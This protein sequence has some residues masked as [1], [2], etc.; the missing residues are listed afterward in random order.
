MSGRS[1]DSVKLPN[2]TVLYGIILT[3]LGIFVLVGSATRLYELREFFPLRLPEQ[4]NEFILN[5]VPFIL[6]T[7]ITTVA[8]LAGFIVGVNWILNGFRQMSRLR[9][10]LRWAGDYYQPESVSLGLKEGKLRSYDK[11]PSI[12]FSLLARLWGNARFISE[13]P[14]EIV[15]WN[16]RFLWKA[17]FIGIA[18]H[19]LFRLL[20]LAPPYLCGLGLG[21]GYVVPSPYPLYNLL[22]A[23]CV[24]RILIALSLTPLRKPVVGREMDSMIVE[25]RGHPSVFFSILEE[26][27]R[28]FAHRGFP[29][30]IYRSRPVVCNDGETL[31]GT[32]IESFPEHV[33]TSCRFAALFS[34]TVGAMM[35]LVGFLQIIFM[36]YPTFSVSYED[37]FRLYLLSL[38]V[39][40]IMNVAII[41]FGKSF[42]EQARSLMSIYRFKSNLVYVE[43]KGDFDKKLPDLGKIVSKDRLF[44]PLCQCAFNVRYFSAEAI[45]E[46]VNPEGVRELVGLETSGR[47]AKDI[48]RLKFLPFQVKFVDRYPSSWIQTEEGQN[49]LEQHVPD[50]SETPIRNDGEAISGDVTASSESYG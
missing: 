20:S 12:L 31:I 37:F 24:L 27:S 33:R 22:A 25:G 40:I 42:L 47:L 49:G 44:D 4:V 28:V 11:S 46:S 15:R 8:A 9:V 45:S 36:Q 43:A 30:R 7:F 6:G 18:I 2:H 21:T 35:I 34:L 29:N 26:G 10:V 38:L 23:V 17:L 5:Y 39:D 13:I 19:L 41:I 48:G 32:L 50:A 3:A 1:S 16:V 14:G